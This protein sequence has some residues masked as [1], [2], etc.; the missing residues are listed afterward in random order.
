[1]KRNFLALVLMTVTF[2]ACKKDYDNV[3]D[4][5]PDERINEAL[6]S[7]NTVL[8]GAENGWKAFIKTDSGK[9]ST[10]SFYFKFSADNRVN[11]FSDFDSASAVKSQQTSYRLKAQQQPTL[12]FDTYSYVHVLADP[13]ESVFLGDNYILFADV[14]LSQ[15]GQ[16]GQGLLSDFEFIFDNSRIKSDTVELTGKVHNTRLIMVKATKAEEDAYNSGQL[17]LGLSINKILTYFKRLTIGAQSYDVTIDP[18]TRQ[19][20][21]SW[22]D[23]GGNLKTFSTGYYFV[24]GGIIFTNPFVDGGLTIS[25]FTNVTWNPST[26]TVSLT[27]SDN[28][29][30][31]IKGIVVPV[32]V[33]VGAPRRWYQYAI[34]NGASYWAA[35]TGFHVNGVDDAFGARS[36]KVGDSSFY[37]FIYWPKVTASNDF[38][39]PV[40]IDAAQTG[41]DL[42]YGTAPGIPTFTSD[43][44]AIFS[45]HPTR[46]YGPPNFLPYP[47]SGPAAQTRALLYNSSGYYF[48]QTSE[49]TYDM[50]SAQDGK[51][52]ITW[53]FLF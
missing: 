53:Y 31:T 40:F 33:D 45:P 34:N 17:N 18:L 10:Y 50:V 27:A 47:T 24:V 23:A 39:G 52:W 11:M 26:E 37:Y 22:V 20:T 21:F 25:G 35:L 46:D 13:N 36:L 9:G 19:F 43:G 14:N 2:T 3:F 29:P 49:T 16:I 1:M 38:F 28:T 48:V 42:F 51:S 8:T 30:A 32:R 5:S 6:A 41:V 12:I 44:R 4:K 7:Y 15:G